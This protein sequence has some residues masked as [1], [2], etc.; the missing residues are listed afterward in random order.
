MLRNARIAC[1]TVFLLMVG[2]ASAWAQRGTGAIEGRILDPQAAALP[3][4][5][6]TLQGTGMPGQQTFTTGPDGAFRFPGVPPGTYTLTAEL[7]GFGTAR[8]DDLIVHIGL[9]VTLDL[10]L[11]LAS[12]QESVTVTGESPIVDDTSNTASVNFGKKQIDSVTIKRDI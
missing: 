12:V 1:A 3:G 2:A 6:L 11:Q 8:R 5:T 10:T 4:V 7:S 9:T